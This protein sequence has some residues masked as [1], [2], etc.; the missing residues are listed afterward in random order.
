M[1]KIMS[2]L[3]MFKKINLIYSIFKYVYIYNKSKFMST[4]ANES[5]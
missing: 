4:Q 5:Q 3:H 1:N 2:Y